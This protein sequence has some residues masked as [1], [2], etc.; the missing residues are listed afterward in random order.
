MG[1]RICMHC[2]NSRGNSRRQIND[3]STWYP[4]A[5]QHISIQTFRELNPRPT[6]SPISRR[7]EMSSPGESFRS[8]A[9]HLEEVC[10]RLTM[11]MQRR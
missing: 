8:T 11:L 5:D 9:D 1:N 2:F 10:N 7:T 6:S 4:Q 3:S